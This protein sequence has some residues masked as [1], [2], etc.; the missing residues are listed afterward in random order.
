MVVKAAMIKEVPG[1][2]HIALMLIVLL[3]AGVAA[4]THL[5]DEVT[6][7]T[8]HIDD[9]ENIQSELSIVLTELNKTVDLRIDNL[10]IK[11]IE[12]L[13]RLEEQLR[14]LNEALKEIKQNQ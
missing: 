7:N 14:Y 13:A 11:V 9:I 10:E 5:Q 4:F 8:E 6:K 3:V 12:Q 2:F 1:W